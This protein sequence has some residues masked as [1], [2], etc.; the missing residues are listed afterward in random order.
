MAFDEREEEQ[1]Y[2][3]SNFIKS[4]DMNEK[5]YEYLVSALKEYKLTKD[6]HGS[7]HSYLRRTDRNSMTIRFKSL[8]G[9]NN[10]GISFDAYMCGFIPKPFTFNLWKY[11]G[12]NHIC[13]DYDLTEIR[14]DDFPKY[15]GYIKEFYGIECDKKIQYE[16]LSL[17]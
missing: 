11:C 16:Q 17:F 15:L 6:Y 2:E 9:V 7:F 13:K 12:G 8:K 3:L 10:T 5:F 4:Q 1:K 14:E